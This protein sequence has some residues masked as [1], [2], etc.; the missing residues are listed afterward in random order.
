M[1]TC[2]KCKRPN[3]AT[4]EFFSPVSRNRD[5]L[6][7]W[8]RRCMAE[9]CSRWYQN[10]REAIS[11]IAKEAYRDDPTKF[12]KNAKRWRKANPGRKDELNRAWAASNPQKM[13]ASRKR[14]I[15]GNLTKNAEAQRRRY[16][17]RQYGITP[18]DYARLYREQG[19]VCAICKGVPKP[20][21]RFHVDH[22]HE[23]GALRSLLCGKC[24]TALGM[25]L[26]SPELLREAAAYLERHRKAQEERIRKSNLIAFPRAQKP[27]LV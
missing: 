22:D 1:K 16:L 24:N 4:T 20:G 10:N 18:E 2:S 14:W 5:G 19:G 17:K 11:E 26:D 21:E 15:M 27:D 23:T 25:F 6:C 7:S 3:P 9:N 8:C 13:R 12:K